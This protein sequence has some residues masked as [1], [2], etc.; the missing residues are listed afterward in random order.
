ETIAALPL[1][2][3]VFSKK[4]CGAH[5]HHAVFEPGSIL[6]LL[7]DFRAQARCGCWRWCAVYLYGVL[8]PG[9]SRRQ[10]AQGKFRGFLPTHSPHPDQRLL[11]VA[12]GFAYWTDGRPLPV[13]SLASGLGQLAF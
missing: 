4:S 2:V 5:D 11:R 10:L 3:F 9:L 7:D 1:R 12:D 13:W 8:L 6:L